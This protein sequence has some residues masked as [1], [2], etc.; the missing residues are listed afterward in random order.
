MMNKQIQLKALEA[1][2]KIGEVLTPPRMGIFVF[3]EDEKKEIDFTFDE[4]GN[5]CKAKPKMVDYAEF[6]EVVKNAPKGI[7]ISL[8]HIVSVNPETSHG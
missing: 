2:E 5:Y 6:K 4:L 3:L 8:F 7:G 1:I